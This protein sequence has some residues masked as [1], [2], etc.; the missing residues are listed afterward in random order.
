MFCIS[1]FCQGYD[2][3]VIN[4]A[5]AKKLGKLYIH[6]GTGQVERMRILSWFQHSPQVNTIFLSK[7]SVRV[8]LA[9]GVNGRLKWVRLET[10]RLICRKQ[11]V[12]SRY[13]LI[14]GHV[15]RKLRD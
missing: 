9:L 7:A 8:P 4:Q 14:L 6:G 5:Y 2:H 1:H 12:S 3:P 15:D 10:P 13:L 11:H